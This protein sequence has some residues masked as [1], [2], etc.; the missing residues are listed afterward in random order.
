MKR[1]AALLLLPLLMSCED[2]LDKLYPQ[3][4]PVQ[5]PA[6]TQVGA[7]TFGCSLN[8][9]VWEASHA[10]TLRGDVLTPSAS[11]KRG[12]LEVDAFRRLQVGGPITNFHFA[13]EGV[14]GPGVYRLSQ[15]QPGRLVRLK[16]A[17]GSVE[18]TAGGQ[19]PGTI[20]IT[21]LDTAGAHPYVA[22]RFELRAEPLPGTRMSGDLP[23]EVQVTDGRFDIQLN[24]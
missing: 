24:R 3:A 8:G 6:V 11:F 15:S 1:S 16:T 7:N 21:R 17:G 12:V 10:T 4:Q 9:Q 2:S 5:L 14:T 19:R 20:T 23:A 22:G 13:L 18:Y